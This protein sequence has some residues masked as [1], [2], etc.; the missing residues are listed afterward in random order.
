MV[1][2]PYNLLVDSKNVCFDVIHDDGIRGRIL[3]VKDIYNTREM[4]KY[5]N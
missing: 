2:N 5:T 4:I 3:R 1:S